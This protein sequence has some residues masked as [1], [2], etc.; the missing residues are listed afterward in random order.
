MAG[1]FVNIEIDNLGEALAALNRM[2]RAGANL[3]P[4]MADIGEHLLIAADERFDAGESPEG[5]P[6]A[7]LKPDYAARK[8]KNKDRILVLEDMLA[9]TLRYRADARSLLFGT[10]M[11]YGATHQFGREEANIPARPFLGVSAS[12]ETEIARMAMD[13][14]TG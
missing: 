2:A 11:I 12:D 10:N 13:H 4:L 6:W 14:L 3:R 8:K 7:D 9:G 5:E 1:G